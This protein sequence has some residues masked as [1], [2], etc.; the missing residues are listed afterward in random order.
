MKFW[1]QLLKKW[2]ASLESLAKTTYIRHLNGYF[3]FPSGFRVIVV[4]NVKN[5]PNSCK[6]PGY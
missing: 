6:K 2:L 4:L 3:D 1:V 5:M